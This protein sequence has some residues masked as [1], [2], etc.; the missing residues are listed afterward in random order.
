[1]TKVSYMEVATAMRELS[2]LSMEKRGGFGY[3]TGVY[4][5]LLAALVVDLPKH[6]QAEVMRVIKETTESLKETT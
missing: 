3:A 6:K 1:M 5:S 4:E 2:N